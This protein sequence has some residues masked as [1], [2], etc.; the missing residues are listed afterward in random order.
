[1]LASRWLPANRFL[2]FREGLEFL[3][4]FPPLAFLVA[5][6][7]GSCGGKGPTL[8]KVGSGGAKLDCVDSW[9]VVGLAL[10]ERGR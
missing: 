10:P 7:Q 3:S 1:M 5:N 4:S 8:R 9:R 6:W 2:G